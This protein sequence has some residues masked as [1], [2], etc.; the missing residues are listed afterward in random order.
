MSEK[1]C[2]TC[3]WWKLNKGNC[4]VAQF[5]DDNIYPEEDAPACPAHAPAGVDPLVARVD[6][7]LN[8]LT[9]IVDLPP[10]VEKAIA[11]VEETLKGRER[12]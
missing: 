11:D 5:F 4:R 9:Y 1:T 3:R 10:D 8:A 7:L 2:G 6:I 12:E